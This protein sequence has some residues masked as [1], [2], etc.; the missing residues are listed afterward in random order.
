MIGRMAVQPEELTKAA[1]QLR[2][3]IR[4]LQ[5]HR[6]IPTET[7]LAREIG[8]SQT[9]FN[10]KMKGKSAFTERDLEQIA[11]W[12][13]TWSEE[14]LEPGDLWHPESVLK[15]INGSLSMV[16]LPSGQM[17]LALEDPRQDPPDLAVA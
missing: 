14:P 13:S 4:H 6:G 1:G 8:F 15:R 10:D 3:S 5:A 16:L 17:E 12:A 2:R 9:T 7:A 11:A